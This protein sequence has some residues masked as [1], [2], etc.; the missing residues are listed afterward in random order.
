[1]KRIILITVIL[2]LVFESPCFS[3]MLE[4]VPASINGPR[5]IAKWF[6]TEFKGQLKIPDKPQTPSE[7]LRAK[8][9]DCDDFA[10]LAS[11]ILSQM[12]LRN[13]IIIIKFEGIRIMHAICVWKN[14]DGVYSFLSARKLHRTDKK[15]LLQVIEK[16]YP[17]WEWV[18]FVDEKRKPIKIMTRKGVIKKAGA[19]HEFSAVALNLP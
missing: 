13:E 5:D 2:L 1:M 15:N 18:T 12:G 17:D 7:T 8:T 19:V 10:V 9:G 4:G 16:N 6:S 11:A 3:Q 14:A